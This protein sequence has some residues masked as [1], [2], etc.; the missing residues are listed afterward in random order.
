MPNKQNDGRT[1]GDKLIHLFV[2]LLFTG[3]AYYVTELARLLE[4]S[5][6]TVLRLLDD[7]SRHI[8]L[9]DEQRGRKRYVRIPRRTV[10]P[11]PLSETELLLLQMCRDFTAHLLG[12][13]IFDEI[14]QAML[15]SQT[16]LD[17]GPPQAGPF[18]TFRPGTIDYTPHHLT[19]HT[20]LQAL[21]QRLVLRLSYRSIEHDQ[22][23]ELWVQ[24]LKMFSHREAL[25]LHA[26][27]ARKPGH[28]GA[29]KPEFDPLLAIH[30]ILAAEL[31]DQEAEF[32]ADYDF[33]AFFNRHFGVVKG[34]VFEAEV[35]LSDWAARYAAERTLS[36]GQRVV[37]VDADTIRL[38][39]Q[40]SSE[41]EVLSWLFSFR[42]HARL[43][44]PQ[45]LVDAAKASLEQLRAMYQ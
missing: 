4:C 31:T 40:A 39:F 8:E 38:I 16:L 10:A 32:P 20:V 37:Q 6:P 14:T 25:Y 1:Y 45:P 26:R 22:A 18:G 27:L 44:R 35:E 17:A 21:D 24:P 36:P 43:I 19:I 2:R 30:R 15:K 42:E 12:K 5:K 29:F 13:Q 33:E 23:R 41:W 9:K 7:L 3:E 34:E 11:V 28:T